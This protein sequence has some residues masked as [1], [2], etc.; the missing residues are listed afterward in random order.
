M[1]STAP[2]S[3]RRKNLLQ[4]AS[5]RTLA[6][7]AAFG[8][9]A[10]ATASAA[11]SGGVVIDGA[12]TIGQSGAQ[13]TVVQTTDKGIID[14]DG[15]SIATGES[16]SFLQPNAGSITLNRVVGGNLSEIHGS[17]TSNGRLVLINPKGI[18]FGEG[19][20][21]DVGGLVATTSD[22]SNE[23]FMAGR[24]LF[25]RPGDAS[26]SIVN[27]GAI[28]AADAGI[29]AFVAPHVRNSGVIAANL[30]TV[31]LAAGTKFALDLYGDN[32]VSF[33]VDA[34]V[35]EIARDANGDAVAALVEADGSIIAKGGTIAL[36]AAA[37]RGL[38]DD[39]IIADGSFIA[40]SAHQ[41]GG[42]IILDGGTNGAVKATG[43]FDASGAAK[44]RI[45]VSGESVYADGAFSA[46]GSMT[47]S[48]A[49]ERP[50]ADLR[51]LAWFGADSANRRPSSANTARF[52]TTLSDGGA[53]T[54]DGE[55]WVSIGGNLHANGASGGDITVRAGGLSIAGSLAAQGLSGSGGTIDIASDDSALVFSGATIDASGARGGTI[56]QVGG[57]QIT[58]SGA[59][60]VRGIAGAGG[61]LDMTAP[62]VKLLS[63]KIDASG[64]TD[65]GTVR[66]G[67]EYQGGKN[68][69]TDE[70][71]NAAT[72]IATTGTEINV[73]SRGTAGDGGKVILWSDD[74]TIFLGAVNARPGAFSG[75]GGFVEV[76]SAG[77]LT[78][79]GAV[80]TSVGARTGTVLL[81]PKNITIVDSTF[82]Q[83]S[84]ILGFN[85]VGS[86]IE[87]TGQLD[88][89]DGFGFS[90]GLD[91]NRLAVGSFLDSGADNGTGGAGAVYL[92]SFADSAFN[93]GVL[94]A[95]IGSGYSGGKN[96]DLVQLETDDR[97]GSSVSLD[98]N[99]LAVGAFA[100]DGFGN[101]AADSGAAYLF[102]FADSVFSSGALEATLGAGYAGG[103]NFDVSGL[104]SDD[105]F[106]RGVSLDGNR[107]AV[108]ADGDDG[109]GN[110]VVDAGA[111][112]LF[113]FTDSAF[114][115][116]ALEA[117]IGAG[118]AGGKNVDV[119]Q[120]ESDDAFGQS[121]SIDGN[122]LATGAR[123]DDGAGNSVTDSGAAYVFSFAD[124]AFSTGL[125]EATIGDG[126]VGGK[127]VD[128]GQ[129]D[130][131]DQFG[132]SVSLDG[133]RLAV[134]AFL[135]DGAANGVMDSGAAYLFTFTDPVF[136]G[137]LL[138]ATIG[139]G[140]AGGK[141]VGVGGLEAFDFFAR[142]LSLDGNRI[143]VGADADS[144]A[145]NSLSGAGAAYLFT[146]ADAAF[147][148][149]ALAGTIG[150]GYSG[151]GDINLAP[152]LD[153]SDRFGESVSL[154]GTRLAVGAVWDGGAGNTNSRTGAV[155][156]FEFDDPLFNGASLEAIV[157][158]G[159][160]GGK[161][162]NVSS[163]V[164]N[165]VFGYGVSLDGNRLAVGSEED[166]FRKGNVRLFSFADA[167]FNG[168]VLEATIGEGYAGGKNID[169]SQIENNDWFGFGVSLEGDTLAVG[170]FGD[171]GA[172]NAVSNSG[173]VYLFTFADATFSGGVLA[174]TIGDGYVGGD[175]VDF[176]PLVVNSAFGRSV[177]LDGL[178]LAAGA[179]GD[180][181]FGGAPTT[182]GAVHL[183]SFSGSAFSGGAFEASIG[184]GFIGGNNIDIA[185]LDIADYFGQSVSLDG[186]R[187]AIGAPADDGFLNANANAGAAYL[188]SFA[189]TSF[190]GGAVGGTVGI[191]YSGGQS[192]SLANLA[193]GDAFGTGVSVD[194]DRLAVG[195]D[196]DDG[197]AN[198]L[199]NSGAVYLFNLLGD[200]SSATFANNPSGDSFITVGALK[201]LLDAGNAVLL[202]ANNDL[203]LAADLIVNNPSGDGGDIAFQAGRSIFLNA[204]IFSDNGNVSIGANATLADG[205]IDADRDPGAAVL[206]MAA[207]TSID[208][209][210][211]GVG[212]SLGDGAGKTHSASGDLTVQAVSAGSGILVVSEGA[213][214]IV[215]DGPIT[216]DNTTVLLA[217]NDININANIATSGDVVI[218]AGR[219]VFINADISPDDSDLVVV[220]NATLASGVN[221]AFRDPGVAVLTM[222]PGAAIDTGTGSVFL[223]LDDGAGKTNFAS[224]DLTLQTIDANAIVAENLG[225]GDLILD[226]ALSADT[227]TT[228]IVLAAKFGDFINGFG[229]G[230]VDPGAGRF[231][232]YSQNATDNDFGGLLA[233]PYYNTVYNPSSP[234]LAATAGSR[235]VYTLAP[236]LTVA[237]D[238]ASR[239]QGAGDPDFDA[240]ISGYLPGDDPASTTGAP[241]FSTSATPS[242]AP[243][244]YAITPSLGTLASDFNYG[245]SF[246]DGTLTVT[247]APPPPPPPPPPADGGE[248]LGQIASDPGDAVQSGSGDELDDDDAADDAVFAQQDPDS[249]PEEPQSPV[250]DDIASGDTTP[251]AAEA[252]PIDNSAALEAV[253][254]YAPASQSRTQVN[255]DA[256]EAA[257]ER[258][259][260]E[261]LAP[262]LP[263]DASGLNAARLPVLV[264]LGADAG[265]LSIHS[266]GDTYHATFASDGTKF[267]VYG[268]R[269]LTKFGGDAAAA[270]TIHEIIRMEY[271]LAV[272][273]SVY[274]AVYQV[275]MFCHEDHSEIELEDHE[276]AALQQAVRELAV[277]IGDSGKARP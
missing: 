138:E 25:D 100:D 21:I 181:G 136:S 78:Y 57:T 10:L 40:T 84:L 263:D 29:V 201:T 133:D 140:Y 79:N 82:S 166:L 16:V 262:P 14:W 137:G 222:T 60:S 223:S 207:G 67:G 134:G 172:G 81:D 247:A 8:V 5:S 161:N 232:I 30:G 9:G 233:N 122:R 88:V 268:T 104:E 257:R 126:Y 213:G 129:L 20:R 153:A 275:T 270:P 248:I 130:A 200:P 265:T 55:N 41:E 191:G 47:S 225:P 203:T 83:L 269:V 164:D 103:K 69:A 267:A 198:T 212:L 238:D 18:L 162:V 64:G 65:G 72:L 6:A 258:Q 111:A 75:A 96:I 227:G 189:D 37:A 63:A 194:G 54:L 2:A 276:L 241:G 106:G 132:Q 49:R 210:T 90:V 56:T 46:D 151:A 236:T 271:G 252:T 113:S 187:L 243:G 39:V 272:S 76:S 148:G 169:V 250:Y 70:L 101:S 273:V 89:N 24:F 77:T 45:V 115:G 230:A 15:F 124:A 50:P 119:S 244:D 38:I 116:G 144:G 242:S 255:W 139:S 217:N 87:L 240:V 86:P 239:L 157:G 180:D 176:A 73:A 184:D 91:G 71:P 186:T 36:T 179:S 205:V 98:G 53:I 190:N 42:T 120:L 27:R 204:D 159:Y 141:N 109:S 196:L 274:G 107:V 266:N 94:E 125:Q 155:Y 93:G 112:Y 251:A 51:D 211:G 185:A 43:S 178:R 150:S 85:Y 123:G 127:N 193:N 256:A 229:A 110:A 80:E 173:A 277:L 253:A 249:A 199:S 26:A 209:G 102:S 219:S 61:A 146:F 188:I 246:A 261:G 163:L 208:A 145:G 183:F 44:G 23:N 192:I 62:V 174:A 215:V 182:E 52:E 197:S 147:N 135:D 218:R 32:L 154:D 95:V 226:G 31:A 259:K 260:S 195:A 128:V 99:R 228:P 22:I 17:L 121:V 264:S 149:G 28:T 234:D 220:A 4:F 35:V 245:F 117:T 34:D 114:S 97:F 1:R 224:G 156:L 7:A 231:L 68:L 221:D 206:S 167:S 202:Q 131:T 216:A 235:F 105:L 58:T 237:A 33:A 168:G 3:L 74:Q 165:E 171:D 48:P 152:A 142:S 214:N 177:S 175:N 13:T 66:L 12:A 170:A 118:Y 108:G 19:A 254:I 11:P 59:Y 160:T 158:K 92:F 143:A